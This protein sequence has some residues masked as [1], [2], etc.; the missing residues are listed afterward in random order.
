MPIISERNG[1]FS[2]VNHGSSHDGYTRSFDMIRDMI[3]RG[4]SPTVTNREELNG[5]ISEAGKDGK[6]FTPDELGKIGFRGY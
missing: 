5:I 4:G 2:S 3:S 1:V 6:F